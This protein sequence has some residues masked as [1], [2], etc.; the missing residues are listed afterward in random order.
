MLPAFVP[1]LT[2]SGHQQPGI[3]KQAICAQAVH[4][5]LHTGALLRMCVTKEHKE[6]PKTDIINRNSDCDQ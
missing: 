6:G 2:V 5:R 1:V 4:E 3:S